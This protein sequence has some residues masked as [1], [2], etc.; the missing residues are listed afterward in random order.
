M[1]FI[2]YEDKK[3]YDWCKTTIVHESFSGY[4]EIGTEV[5]IMHIDPIRGYTIQDKEENQITEIG[6][7]I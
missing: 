4:F 5:Q 7:I 6:W 2:R 3:L 1:A